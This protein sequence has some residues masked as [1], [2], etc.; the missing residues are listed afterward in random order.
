MLSLVSAIPGLAAFV[1]GGLAGPAIAMASG[2]AVDKRDGG[3]ALGGFDV[4]GA[5]AAIRGEIAH[6]LA[7][8]DAGVQTS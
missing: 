6:A 8:G 7:G 2:E 5:H 4:R 1:P 3:A